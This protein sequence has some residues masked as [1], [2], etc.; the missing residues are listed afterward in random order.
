MISR[1]GCSRQLVTIT[2]HFH[3]YPVGYFDQI[4]RKRTHITRRE[5]KKGEPPPP[6]REPTIWKDIILQGKPIKRVESFCYLGRILM[7]NGM[8][9]AELKNR[10]NEMEGGYYRLNRD[11]FA[12]KQ[13]TWTIKLQ[14][15]NSCV[16]SNALY[17]S[18]VWNI[19]P[20]QMQAVEGQ[21]YQLL[22]RLLGYTWRDKMSHVRLME[23][24]A[25][26]GVIILPI[27][28]KIRQ[29]MMRYAGH[30]LRRQESEGN[31][32][33]MDLL[34]ARIVVSKEERK[35]PKSHKNTYVKT[36]AVNLKYFG[37]DDKEWTRKACIEEK[38][39]FAKY[40]VGD[41]LTHALKMWFE[42]ERKKKMARQKA[43][44]KERIKENPQ[45]DGKQVVE[46]MRI[47]DDRVTH[48]LM[49]RRIQLEENNLPLT[50]LAAAGRREAEM[51]KEKEELQE[52]RRQDEHDRR[53]ARRRRRQIREESDPPPP[54]PPPPPQDQQ[55]TTGPTTHH[56]T[57]NKKNNNNR[58]MRCHQAGAYLHHSSCRNASCRYHQYQ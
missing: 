25:M 57:N 31:N 21:Q 22:S 45:D 42:G 19:T 34:K 27:E 46:N 1:T 44:Q 14:F 3:S 17:G 49:M 5:T 47:F 55:P 38:A 28:A 2:S 58:I 33:Q 6:G 32:S 48:I 36:M 54:P 18:N 35:G 20:K 50:E 51:K 43:A 39:A 15:F 9:D 30:L 12:F 53:D 41:G 7:K 16:L 37:L 4:K 56:R 23:I 26:K 10:P 29:G 40:L 24:A 11:V 52:W 8:L 13:T